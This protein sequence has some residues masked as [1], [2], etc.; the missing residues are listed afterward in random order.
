MT[1]RY[2][3]IGFSSQRVRYRW[4]EKSAQL[5]LAGLPARAATVELRS[6][7]ENDPR[8]KHLA[9]ASRKR[10][11]S[12]LRRTWIAPP[13]PVRSLRDTA[14]SL[15]RNLPRSDHLVIHWGMLM[16]AYPFWAD[17][18]A[19]AGRLLSMQERLTARQLKRRLVEQ[20][21]DREIVLRA[22]RTVLRTFVDW[23]TLKE[24]RPGIYERIPPI[25]VRHETTLPWLAEIVML[26]RGV[27]EMPL[28]AFLSAPELFPFK[29]ERDVVNRHSESPSRLELR[30]D[31]R[32]S[33]VLLLS[34]GTTGSG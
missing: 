21:G 16:A 29:I 11:V 22:T 30:P 14:A 31:L 26:A 3:K 20:Y 7:L 27:S 33:A 9:A 1:R 18:A 25:P 23:G 2:A 15:L 5:F 19:S 8:E 12:I 34:G 24:V 6:L 4:I 28:S 32:G 17:V 13:P 10:A